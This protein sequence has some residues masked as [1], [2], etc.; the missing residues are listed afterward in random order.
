MRQFF[1]TDHL[2]TYFVL[3]LGL[4]GCCL[5]ALIWTR[6][7][8]EERFFNQVLEELKERGCEE[9]TRRQTFAKGL[10]QIIVRFHRVPWEIQ[11]TLTRVSTSLSF[12]LWIS[13]LEDQYG[14]C[15]FYW[16]KRLYCDWTTNCV[17]DGNGLEC[18]SPE[19]FVQHAFNHFGL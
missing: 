10:Q 12:N 7:S 19:F 9:R 8:L 4:N 16:G 2:S 3:G 5:E 1:L 13:N 14:D 15:S 11:V 6:V 18:P 17:E